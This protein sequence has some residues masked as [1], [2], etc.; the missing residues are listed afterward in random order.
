MTKEQVCV[1]QHKDDPEIIEIYSLRKTSQ[2]PQ[3]VLWASVHLDLLDSLGF[4][5]ASDELSSLQLALVSK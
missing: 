1:R 3:L 5:W 4:D 2:G